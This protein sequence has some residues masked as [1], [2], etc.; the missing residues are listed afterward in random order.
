[1]GAK[2][3]SSTIATHKAV[4]LR[5]SQKLILRLKDHSEIL[6]VEAVRTSPR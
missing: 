3:S 2:K 6:T 5:K 1:M 4:K